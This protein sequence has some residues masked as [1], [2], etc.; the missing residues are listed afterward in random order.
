MLT[1]VEGTDKTRMDLTVDSALAGSQ[2]FPAR[3][4]IGLWKF[5]R[6]LALPDGCISDYQKLVPVRGMEELTDGKTQRELLQEAGTSISGSIGSTDPTALHDTLLAGFRE[7]KEHYEPGAAN[8]VIMLTDGEN[9]D[10]G[11]ISQEELISTIQAEQDADEPVFI[12]LIGIS[13]DA[14]ME[15]LQTIAS[16]TGGEAYPAL[17]PTDVQVIFSEGLTQVAAKKAKEATL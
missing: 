14:N 4:S 7:L 9:Y 5:S 12:L 8:V 17:S 13:Q 15:A 11:S 3:D 10:E 6:N 1:P 16:V 2:L